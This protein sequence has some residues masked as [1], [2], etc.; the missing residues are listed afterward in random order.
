MEQKAKTITIIIIGLIIIA[1][2]IFVFTKINYTEPTQNSPLNNNGEGIVGADADEHGCIASAGYLWCAAKQKCLRPFEEFCPEAARIIVEEIESASGV[3]LIGPTETSFNWLVGE[4]TAQ[5]DAKITGVEYSATG[6]NW[7]NYQKIE[8]YLNDNIGPDPNNIV[9]GL[10]T[11]LRGYYTSYM[12]CQLNFFRPESPHNQPA[13]DELTIYFR[14]GFFNPNNTFILLAEQKIKEELAIK[15]NQAI[16][17]IKVNILRYDENHLV[18]AIDLAP[19]AEGGQ[20]MFLAIKDNSDWKLVYDGN[21]SVDCDKI[22]N[23]WGFS[24]DLLKPEFC[25]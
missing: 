10:T 21:G 7:A 2:G 8:K 20:G 16:N 3:K 18:G 14:C 15:Y 5:A 11:G 19:K 13:N 17:E 9:D 6:I 4:A 25:D 12:A 22:K 24:S 23:D 1:L